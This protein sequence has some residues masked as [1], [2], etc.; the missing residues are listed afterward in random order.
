MIMGS[1]RW[2]RLDTFGVL[3]RKPARSDAAI[4]QARLLLQRYGILVKEFYRFEH[5]LLPWYEIFQALKKLEWQGE[6]R[7]G[8]FAAGLSGIQFALPEAV[9]IL[10]H[11]RTDSVPCRLINVLDPALP[12]GANLPWPVN[13]DQTIQRQPGNHIGFLHGRP[14][15]YTENFFSRWFTTQGV[16]GDD[17][18]GIVALTRNWLKMPEPLRTKRKIVV[19]H[20]NRVPAA[21]SPLISAFLSVGYEQDGTNLILW[22]SAL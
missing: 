15:V 9:E 8:Y 16:N 17:L 4:W 7:R 2:F 14:I 12:F 6:I 3:G 22:P 5:G 18:G 13:T 11:G 10:A 19:E 1:G 20:I 21:A